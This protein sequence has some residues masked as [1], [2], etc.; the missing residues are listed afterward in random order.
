MAE[1]NNEIK[2][3]DARKLLWSKKKI[4]IKWWIAAFVLSCVWI[5]PQPRYYTAEI[6]LAPEANGESTSS[7]AGIASSFGIKLGGGTTVDALYPSLYPE[8]MESNDFIAQIMPIKVTTYDSTVVADYYTYLKRYQKE[9]Y[10]LKPFYFMGEK[11]SAAFGNDKK[12]PG[13]KVSE[14]NPFSLSKKDSE[15][16]SMVKRKIKCSVDKKT[17]VI[18]ISVT[19]QDRLVCATLADSVCQQLQN[20]II[21]Y[22]TKKANADVVH[23]KQLSDSAY[24]EYQEAINEYARFCDANQETFLQSVNSKRDKLENK[25]QLKYTT[26]QS[27]VVQLEGAKAKLQER[28]PAFTILSGASVPVLPA[29]PKRMQFV[30]GMLVLVTIILIP[31]SLG[32]DAFMAL[33]RK[34]V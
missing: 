14:L 2:F 3:S 7:L 29:G 28:T 22:R 11:L 26:Y 10:L 33:L 5:F 6:S 30:F 23:Y 19:D 31:K 13:T 17:D 16:F 9:N 32:W 24:A 18:T 34:I 15:L 12:V 25:M 1:K 21:A 8:L 20:A 4:F 27:L